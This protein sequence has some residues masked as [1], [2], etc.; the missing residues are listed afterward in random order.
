MRTD[1]I[2]PARAFTVVELLVV[3]VIIMIVLTVAT[4]AFQS[5]V[6][7]AARSEAANTVN[8]AALAAREL[9]LRSPSGDDA[10]VVFVHDRDGAFRVIPAVRVGSILEPVYGAG[11]LSGGGEVP[12]G[13]RPRVKRDVFAP[14]PEM[15]GFQMPA[16]W[17][18]RGY[19]PANSMIEYV[20]G[21]RPRED[22]AV[23]YNSDLYGGTEVSD[24][25][26]NPK[27]E[28]NWVF[29][30]TA[31][32]D[33]DRQASPTGPNS[34]TGRQ[35]FMIRF[36]SATG[37][38][39]A[40]RS[41][42][43]FIDPRPSTA[44]RLGQAR[45]RADERWLRPDRA[46][47]LGDWARAIINSPPFAANGRPLP[48][49]YHEGHDTV[50]LSYIGTSSND[51]I[52]VKPVTRL[53]VYDERAMARDLGARGLNRA[54]Q[55]LYALPDPGQGAPDIRIDASLFRSGVPGDLRRLI[56]R[57]IDGDT[58][59]PSGTPDGVIDENDRP[60]ARI[61]LVR[62]GTGDLTE[63]LR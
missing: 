7:S 24:T 39:S 54:T 35:S 32:Y 49:P 62:P 10:A 30:E 26:S 28:G 45:P 20:A 15:A 16:F 46:E 36:D 9:A 5:M 23:W 33:V 59:G 53:A 57:W 19:A 63:V 31:F 3:L 21:E 27:R 6:Y 34:R 22:F 47:H 14:V 56:N 29:P 52:L 25:T 17:S 18:V 37:A 43:L 61:F 13:G 42:A 11:G 12:L 41:P 4:P 58:T 1:R 38:V 51:T 44:D 60:Q 40:D 50:R 48:P 2:H 55:S 8:A